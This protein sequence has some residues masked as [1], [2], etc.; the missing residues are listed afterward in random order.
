MADHTCHRRLIEWI[1]AFAYR[2]RIPYNRLGG[3]LYNIICNK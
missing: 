1:Y 3:G 2:L